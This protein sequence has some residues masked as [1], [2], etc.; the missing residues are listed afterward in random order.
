MPKSKDRQAAR[1]SYLFQVFVASDLPSQCRTDR[2]NQK[3][4]T[5]IGGFDNQPFAERIN[6][7]R[8]KRIHALSQH[9]R[10]RL[11]GLTRR[12]AAK[13]PPAAGPLSKGLG[14]GIHVVIGE[15]I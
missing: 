14:L 2:V 13:R 6:C 4:E 3:V 7:K 1:S 12:L 11:L 15:S 10:V 8:G 9:F 5:Q